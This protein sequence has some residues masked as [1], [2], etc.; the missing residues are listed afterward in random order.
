MISPRVDTGSFVQVTELVGQSMSL[1]Q[2]DRLCH[3]YYWA[4]AFCDNKD[5]IELAC[6]GGQGLAILASRAKSLIG[7][8]I[9]PE[10]LEKAR[11]T[12]QKEIALE[13]FPAEETPY[14]AQTF[15]VVLLFE[16]L[17]YLPNAEAFV[18]EAAR[19]LRPGGDLLIVTANK[20]LY[21]FTR[22]PFSTTYYGVIELN[23]MLKGAGFITSFFG[24]V[25][26]RNISFRQKIFRPFKSLASK[27]NLAPKTMTSK[28]IVKRIIFGAMVPMPNRIDGIEFRYIPPNRI[29]HDQK[30]T[31]HKVIYC[32]AKKG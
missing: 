15:D 23:L 4:Q 18:Q 21:D 28:F 16:A 22:S 9:S 12:Y 10:V 25:D 8:D 29:R 30:D 17:Y 3:R 24:Y 1:E 13:I 6:G 7:A 32:A 11:N 20:D 19:L 5:V 27:L 2:R 26:T 14:G 31:F